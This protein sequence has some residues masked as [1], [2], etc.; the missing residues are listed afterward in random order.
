M[1]NVH[2]TESEWL[3]MN[4]LW[5]GAP[6]TITQLVEITQEEKGWSKHTVITMLKRMEAKGLVAYEEGA[7]AKL[8]YPL[9]KRE[10]VQVQETQSL[11]TR[12]YDGSLG[13]LVNTIVQEKSLSQK[14][15]DE[16]YAILKKAEEG[17][18]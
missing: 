17:L 18:K 8:Y 16:L 11:L 7:R 15:I 4:P 10:D 12:A 1:N 14:E 2:L 13:L 9:V 3:L 5:D 6:L